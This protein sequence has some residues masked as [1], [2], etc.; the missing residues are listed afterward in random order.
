[1]GR[2][3]IDQTVA[4]QLQGVFG[5]NF[6]LNGSTG[7][8]LRFTETMKDLKATPLDFSQGTWH[9]FLAGIQQGQ[10]IWK[11]F[12]DAGVNALGRIAEK[13][14]DKTLDNFVSAL[15]G[16]VSSSSGVLGSLF[17]GGKLFAAA[18]GG[19]F[20]PGWGVVGENGPE[21]IRV[22]NGGVTVYP[23]EVSKPYLPGFANGGT[24]SALGNVT[25]LPQGGQDSSLA[26]P[27]QLA[28]NVN[29]SGA[30][31]NQ[32][33]HDMVSAGVASG[34]QQFAKSSQF[35]AGTH[36]AI[37]KAYSVGNGNLQRGVGIG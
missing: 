12:G 15:F 22:F 11:S 3:S 23:H 2:N 27:S 32:E 26:A 17:V 6:D 7:Q 21:I 33:I 14:G 19:T 20:G 36:A 25:R 4:G 9:T 16:G 10:S 35:R 31:G 29:V 1:L 24:L 8:L 28:I 5:D 34:I 37:R 18:G 30:R 13:L